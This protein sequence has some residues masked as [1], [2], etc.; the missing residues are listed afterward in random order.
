[1]CGSRSGTDPLRDAG[2]DAPQSVVGVRGAGGADRGS[3]PL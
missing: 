3:R 2:S 1:M